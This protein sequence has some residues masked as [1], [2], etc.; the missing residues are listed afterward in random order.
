M[1][2]CYPLHLVAMIHEGSSLPPRHRL[3]MLYESTPTADAAV[4]ALTR[5]LRALLA[6]PALSYDQSRALT[7]CLFVLLEFPRIDGTHCV[8]IRIGQRALDTAQGSLSLGLSIEIEP[9]FIEASIDGSF[10]EAEQGLHD[11]VT[12]CELSASGEVAQYDDYR[13]VHAQ[14]VG[15]TDLPALD[16]ASL[17]ILRL[18][19][20]VPLMEVELPDDE[21]SDEAA[22]VDNESDRDDDAW[23]VCG[24]MLIASDW[25]DDETLI[26]LASLPT[27]IHRLCLCN[28]RVSDTGIASLASLPDLVD[29]NVSAT[30]TTDVGVEH[31][32]TLIALEVLDLSHTD[33]TD[34]AL[35]VI[36][37]LPRL[38]CLRIRGTQV[39][40]EGLRNLL[41]LPVLRDIDASRLHGDACA[42]VLAEMPSLESLRIYGADLSGKGI[43]A[44][45]GHEGLRHL[46]AA[47]NP[48]FDEDVVALQRI[49]RLETVDLSQTMISDASIDS[50]AACTGLRRLDIS[51]TY[52]TQGGYEQ[53]CESLPGCEVV[54]QRPTP[55]EVPPTTDIHMPF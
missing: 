54:W 32:A 47:A 22:D 40:P 25:C 31:M 26:A 20:L 44:F 3:A 23:E 36:S 24:D 6:N 53:L 43:G 33:I 17:A 11:S 38:Y 5:T 16:D 7:R 46:T 55:P 28:T 37:V 42:I 8:R 50:L 27:G 18:D 52:V 9:G 2:S 45:V 21:T 10:H 4:A 15:W 30:A 48:I 49:P 34:K 29:L 41:K 39:T 35:K 14:T 19:E 13:H 12:L 1:G 51:D